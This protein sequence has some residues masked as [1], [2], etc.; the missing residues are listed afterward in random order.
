[1]VIDGFHMENFRVIMWWS[2]NVG[3][4]CDF[5]VTFLE[6]SIGGLCLCV[7]TYV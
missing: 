7:V 6:V 1:M 5:D 3:F 4:E 2:L